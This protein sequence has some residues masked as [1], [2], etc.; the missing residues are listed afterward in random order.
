MDEA[1][2]FVRKKEKEVW[3]WIALERN[4]RKIISYAVGDRSVGTFKRLWDGI[5]GEIKQKAIFYTD[6]W[7]AYNLIPY[8]QRIIRKGGTNHVERLFLTLRNDNPRFARK[9]IRFSRSLEML[10]I[11]SNCGFITIIYQHYSDTTLKATLK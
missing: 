5:G 7:D 6:R 9:S 2:S 8:K 11:Q 10:E 4:S 1:W 3:I